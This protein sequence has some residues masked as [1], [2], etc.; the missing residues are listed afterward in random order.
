MVVPKKRSRAKKEKSCRKREVVPKKRSRAKKKQKS[1]QKKKVVP[2]R[3]SRENLYLD[4]GLIWLIDDVL[5]YHK[6]NQCKN[7]HVDKCKVLAKSYFGRQHTPLLYDKAMTQFITQPFPE[8][9]L[10]IHASGVLEFLLDCTALWVGRL[11]KVGID[12]QLRH[13]G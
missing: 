6:K 3:K 13:I 10:I 2:K 11:R 9:K 12:L 4:N 7:I 5:I 1:C 8:G